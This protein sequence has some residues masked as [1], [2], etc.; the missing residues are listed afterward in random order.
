MEI[1]ITKWENVIVFRVGLAILVNFI[2]KKVGGDQT[3]TEDVKMKNVIDL[4]II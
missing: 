4:Q 1:V 3:V 2:A